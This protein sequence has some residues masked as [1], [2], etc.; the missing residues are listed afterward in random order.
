[1][2]GNSWCD[3]F[4]TWL[5]IYNFNPLD[6]NLGDRLLGAEAT[7]WSELINPNSFDWKTW[8][9]SISL[10]MRLWNVDEKLA[11]PD[12]VKQLI[13]V[14]NTLKGEGIKPGPISDEYCERNVDMC[15]FF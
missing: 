1:L 4:K 6:A 10:A 15:F 8:P 9:R 14:K 2:G 13:S 7:L 3:P 11:M 5:H 12:L